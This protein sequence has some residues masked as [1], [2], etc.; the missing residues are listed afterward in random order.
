MIILIT[1]ILLYTLIFALYLELNPGLTNI[2]Y[3]I[4]SD[5]NKHICPSNLFNFIIKPFTMGELWNPEF[6]DTNYWV[7][8]SF[9]LISMYL[10]QNLFS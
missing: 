1:V 6:W 7:G 3:R 10:V 5:G 8:L 9:V 2:W 4:G